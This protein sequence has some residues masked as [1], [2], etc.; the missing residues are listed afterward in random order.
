LR[1]C[2]VPRATLLIV[3][4]A[5]EWT[6]QAQ[7]G[8]RSRGSGPPGPDAADRAALDRGAIERNTLTGEF[9]AHLQ[10]VKQRLKLEP[11]QQA[12]WD[13]YARRAEALML[14]QMRG[15]APPPEHEDAVHQINRRVD[16][17]RNRLAAME[18]I[19]DAA[20]QLYSTLSA[21]QRKIAD[22]LLPTTVPPLYSG[23]PDF[24]HGP[25]GQAMSRKKQRGP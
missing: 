3:L 21:D 17:V 1:A 2:R 9:G 16:I 7:V 25:P 23:L 22:D 19:A 8:G 10:D 15:M 11:A 4:L 6:A 18:D 5:I 12:A 24:S 13:S 14:D 20:G